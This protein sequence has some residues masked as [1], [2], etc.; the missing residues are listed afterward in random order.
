MS[1][2]AFWRSGC[3]ARMETDHKLD[4]IIGT[5]TSRPQQLG[6]AKVSHDTG[7]ARGGGGRQWHTPSRQHQR[8]WRQGRRWTRLG[9]HTGR[10]GRWG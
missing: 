2:H 1:G 8:S 6:L 3:G 10:W 7:E 4:C 5:G 9:T